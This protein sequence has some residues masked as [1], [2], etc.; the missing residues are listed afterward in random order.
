VDLG[1]SPFAGKIDTL[2]CESGTLIVLVLTAF[3][4]ALVSAR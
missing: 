1:T 3:R 4:I 2:L